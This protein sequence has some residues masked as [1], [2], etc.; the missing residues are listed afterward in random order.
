[1]LQHLS[2]QCGG[3]GLRHRLQPKTIK[4]D[5][6]TVYCQVYDVTNGDK[7]KPK[8]ILCDLD[9]VLFKGNQAIPGAP[10]T[11][12]WLLEQNIPHIFLTNN[13]TDTAAG[14]RTKL[15][16]LGI[17]C[18][19]GQILSP[20]T[21]ASQWLLRHNI[22]T[23]ALFVM[24]QLYNEF[25]GMKVQQEQVEAV[26]LGD[27]GE[28]MN[29]RQLNVAFR[30]L[31]ES[32][33]DPV[34]ISLGKSRYF[35]DVDGPSLDVGPF[36]SALEFATGKTAIVLGKPAAEFFKLG[37]QML[38][39]DPCDLVMIGDDIRSDIQAA[40][41]VGIQ[42][43]LVQTGKFKEDDLKLGIQPD[44]LL[45]SISDL[46]QLWGG[47]QDFVLAYDIGVKLGSSQLV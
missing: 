17:P 2:S 14:L 40:Q 28:Q 8:A 21:A 31:M 34:L 45:T 47:E 26:V 32:V 11:V 16:N 30:A 13:T 20:A 7:R 36:A 1:M 12:Q 46:P 25:E 44:E 39:Y 24:E 23:V 22:D 41:Q 3:I 43:W 4:Q 27:M 6:K 10:E 37:A 33:K 15:N 19:K 5:T 42:G 35:Q 29:Y 9:G 18:S 38:G